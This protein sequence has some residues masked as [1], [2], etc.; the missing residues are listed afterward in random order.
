VVWTYEDDR[1]IGSIEGSV[2]G[3]E[4]A[5]STE[6]EISL[7]S[8]GTIYGILT[9]VRLT[10]VKIP[11]GE[12]YAPFK[13]FLGLWPAIEPLVNEVCVDMPF[14]YHCRV[15][16]DRIVI[17][18]FRILLAGPNP[19][20]KLGGLAA[21]EK[22]NG[23]EMFA[24]LAYFQ[25]LGT[26]LEGTYRL[27]DASEKSPP[28]GQLGAPKTRGGLKQKIILPVPTAPQMRG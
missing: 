26:A 9:S 14:S 2:M 13:P 28:K 5:L 4:F 1:V 23:N 6:A 15:Q 21:A 18:N 3:F 16:N 12:D 10:Q 22:G 11:S 25:A 24:G 8:S 27:G 7:S 20:G 17:S 19:L